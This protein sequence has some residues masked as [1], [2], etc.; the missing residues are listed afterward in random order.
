MKLYLYSVLDSMAESYATPFLV[1][2]DG[3][4]KRSFRALCGDPLSMVAK[5]PADFHLYKVGVFDTDNGIIEPIV[6]MSIYNGVDA[7]RALS[8]DQAY[9]PY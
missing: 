2:N 3:L 8:G 4:A 5:S 6:P 9:T 1:M 7:M